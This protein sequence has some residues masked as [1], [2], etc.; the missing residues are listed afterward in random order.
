MAPLPATA[1]LP[2]PVFTFSM[3]ESVSVPICA[4]TRDVARQVDH[5][6]LRRAGVVR[7]VGAGSA[8]QRVVAG[9]AVERVVARLASQCVA[10]HLTR[11]RGQNVVTRTAAQLDRKAP[12]VG[13]NDVVA[14][15]ALNG[16]PT[17]PRFGD[18]GIELARLP[19]R[20]HGAVE[21][22]RVETI[23]PDQRVETVAGVEEVVAA[24]SVGVVLAAGAKID[25]L[26]V[27]G[28]VNGVAE[29]RSDVGFD[30]LDVDRRAADREVEVDEVKEQR[31]ADEGRGVVVRAAVGK[32]VDANHE[33]VIAA[34]AV[35]VIP[36]ALRGAVGVALEAIVPGQTPKSVRSLV[37]EKHVVEVGAL[38]GLN[39]DQRVDPRPIGGG[40]LAVGPPGDLVG[41]PELVTR[42]HIVERHLDGDAG[43]PVG[44]GRRV[45]AAAAV[46][47]VALAA[48]LE[49]VVEVAAVEEI[50]FGAADELLD[51]D[52]GV[53][54]C[55]AT[56]DAARPQIDRHGRVE[57]R[58][59][60]TIAAIDLVANVEEIADPA[61]VS[62][63]EHVITAFA[64]QAIRAAPAFN[65]VL[66]IA[67][68]NSVIATSHPDV[69]VMR[70]C[71]DVLD[72]DKGIALCIA[73]EHLANGQINGD[74]RRRAGEHCPVN[75][76]AAIHV[77][78]AVARPQDVLAVA[79]VH[80]AAVMPLVKRVVPVEALDGVDARAAKK[81]IVDVISAY[82]CRLPYRPW[83]FR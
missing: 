26:A 38:D 22:D 39:R 1:S 29:V 73:A 4:P 48:A 52:E 78:A 21:H 77:I 31:S 7:C 30:L 28:A 54:Q 72:A 25:R 62:A 10:D 6:G 44:V 23:S 80:P 55:L 71:D 2:L 66:A 20:H 42:F 35:H 8:I 27:V 16:L 69:V 59:I 60:E 61:P 74:G 3:L 17:R 41:M 43:G 64:K 40:D 75:T 47:V 15:G 14:A 56:V 36:R 63:D 12:I 13:A 18:G 65:L 34:A 53:F 67:S 51:A 50:A 82:R 19:A 81:V 11:P 5:D 57:D 37:A 68:P 45:V 58:G 46:D 79:T 70:R 9:A 49:P 32:I 83:R 76:I 33:R 24:V